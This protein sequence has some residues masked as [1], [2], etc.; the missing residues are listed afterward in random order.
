MEYKSCRS[1]SQVTATPDGLRQWWSRQGLLRTPLICSTVS[2]RSALS[3]QQIC[4]RMMLEVPKFRA[5]NGMCKCGKQPSPVMPRLDPRCSPLRLK[6]PAWY[7]K[8]PTS[9]LFP[10]QVRLAKRLVEQSF[11]D[12]VF[13]ANSGT[14]ANEAAIKFSRKH[15]RL[16]GVAMA[17]FHHP[18]N[19]RRVPNSF[20][21]PSL[22]LYSIWTL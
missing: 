11:A 10:L 20:L 16:A 17:T 13:Y 18:G 4:S 19:A 22:S 2:L 1:S 3:A 14:E 9:R 12:K 6:S 7:R 21:P 5:C 15:A 8:R